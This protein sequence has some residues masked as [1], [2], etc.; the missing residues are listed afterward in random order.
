MLS[1]LSAH[2]VTPPTLHRRARGLLFV[3]SLLMTPLLIHLARSA[4]SCAYAQAPNAWEVIVNSADVYAGPS[5]AYSVRGRAYL[6]QKLQVVGSSPRQDWL[7]VI[8]PDGKKG[9]VL[10]ESLRNLRRDVNQDPGRFRRQTEYQYDAQG[11]RITPTG[12]AVGSGQ[13]FGR[14]PAQP[15][16]QGQPAPQ[17]Q[18]NP[19]MQPAQG[20][21]MGLPPQ[22]M[23]AG[24]RALAIRVIPAGLSLTSRRFTS[25]V[26]LLSPLA[27]IESE[28][29]L[30]QY[31]LEVGY[32]VNQNLS[33]Q[34]K[35]SDA[36]GAK[37]TLPAHPERP[38]FVPASQVSTSMTVAGLSVQGGVPVGKLWVGGGLGAQYMLHA[39]KELVFALPDLTGFT[40]LQSHSYLSAT[41][42][43]SVKLNLN[44]FDMA[45]NGGVLLPLS[46]SADPY[47]LGPWEGLGYYGDLSLGL[48]FTDQLGAGLYLSAQYMGVDISATGAYSDRTYIYNDQAQNTGSPETYNRASS[49]DVSVNGGLYLQIKL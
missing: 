38:E 47:E 25:D 35:G 19:Q 49:S 20:V 8:T 37:V 6:G 40:P 7:Q 21:A 10:A 22:G 23:S 5:K 42:G 31:G 17:M 12:Q 46:M 4:S 3:A 41:A 9:W 43:A 11:R 13:G 48:M 39:F 1:S 26:K 27:Q 15:T 45:I 33:I 28:S 36:R 18:P 34:L 29:L 14:G 16:P 32:E 44:T 30:Y 2:R 24:R